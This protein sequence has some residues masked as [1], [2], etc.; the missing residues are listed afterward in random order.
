MP[1]LL[2]GP[3]DP[4]RSQNPVED[5]GYDPSNRAEEIGDG[6]LG[7]IAGE[8]GPEAVEE[9]VAG[10]GGRRGG[11]GLEVGPGGLLD[12]VVADGDLAASAAGGGGGLDGGGGKEVLDGG[13]GEWLDGDELEIDGWERLR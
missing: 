3:P 12:E 8:S 10:R 1:L 6:A 7:E 4:N 2:S 5:S 13:V 11:H 9:V